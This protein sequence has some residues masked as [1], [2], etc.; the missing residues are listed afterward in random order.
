MPIRFAEDAA[1]FEG[2]CA[3]E[4]AEPLLE[5]LRGREAPKVDLSACEHAHT[6]VAQLIL[7]FRPAIIAPP[8]DAA[9]ALLLTGVASA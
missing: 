8:P 9:F 7:A 2:V 3:V 5:W 6:A 1:R 4:E